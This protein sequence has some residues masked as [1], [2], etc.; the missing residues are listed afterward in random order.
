MF[1]KKNDN[2]VVRKQRDVLTIDGVCPTCTRGRHSLILMDF[3]PN[4]L[5]PEEG[6]IYIK[7]MSCSSLYQTKVKNV[8]D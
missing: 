3:V 6:H 4:S 8:A 5:K 2:L 1:I 7:C